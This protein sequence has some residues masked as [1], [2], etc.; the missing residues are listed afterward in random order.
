MPIERLKKQYFYRPESENRPKNNVKRNSHKINHRKLFNI[1]LKLCGILAII[2][3]ISFI[4]LSRGLPNPNQL[5]NREVAQSTKIYDRT[6]QTVLYEISGDQKRTL[7]TLND[8]PDNVTVAG[9][10]AKIIEKDSWV[11]E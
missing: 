3:I 4:W 10:P 9:L 2:I 7:V 5:I 6:G 11:Q 1:I 8:I